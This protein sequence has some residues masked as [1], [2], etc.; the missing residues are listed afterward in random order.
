RNKQFIHIPLF[1]QYYYEL[2][3]NQLNPNQVTSFDEYLIIT[4]YLKKKI[5]NGVNTMAKQAFLEELAPLVEQRGGTLQISKRQAYAL[6]KQ[7]RTA[8]NDLLYMGLIHETNCGLEVRQQT[9][10]QFQSDTIAAYFTA[11]HLF[12]SH[13]EV[14]RLID[15]LDR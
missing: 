6:I 8:Y 2:A 5:F 7:Y 4:Q 13:D 3:G 10:I 15:T 14:D 12:N 11:L 1:F 9:V